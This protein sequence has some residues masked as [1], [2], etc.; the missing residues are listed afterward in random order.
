MGRMINITGVSGVGKTTFARRLSTITALPV[1]TEQH[2]ERPF[3]MNAVHGESMLANQIDYLTF[4]AEQEREIRGLENGGIIDGGLETDYY[5]FTRLFHQRGLLT[6]PEYE[7]CSRYFDLIRSFMPPPE[8]T[9]C[10]CAPLEVVTQR[11]Q[12]RNR[13]MEIARLDDL[14]AQQTLLD[15]WL[16]GEKSSRVFRLDA[17]SEDV[18][19]SSAIDQV[20]EF[21]DQKSV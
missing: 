16:T 15:R 9:I 5:I 17:S 12:H 20:L 13:K 8:F 1:F 10:L 6:L 2:K 11:Y 14:I 19:Y 3:H 21:L 7:L 18:S 4:R